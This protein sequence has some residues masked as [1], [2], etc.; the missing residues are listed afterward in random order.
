MIGI[1]AGEALYNLRAALDYLVFGLAWL[2]CGSQQDDT[3]FPIVD[4]PRR[5]S[6]AVQRWMRGVSAEHIDRIVPY[7]PFSGCTWTRKLRD[8]SNP[9]KHRSLTAVEAHYGFGFRID[10]ERLTPVPDD[11]DRLFVPVF[12]Q[13][14]EI[15]FWTR[16]DT[17]VATLRGLVAEVGRVLD[18][19]QG[20]FGES[21]V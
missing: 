9:D 12:D 21:D 1:L 11:P 16:E 3:Q 17:V 8:L 20:D 15:Y 13:S 7:Q 14:A 2:D 10:P 19:F 18:K 6:R 5:W 4:N